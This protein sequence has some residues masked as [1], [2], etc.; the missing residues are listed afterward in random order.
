MSSADNITWTGTFTPTANTED[1]SNTL[2]LATSYTDTAG[3]AGPAATT[4]NYA[5]ET[6]AP[7]IS[8]VTAG[9]GTSLNATEDNSAGTVTVVTS[10]AENGQTVTVSLN[11]TN[12]TGTVSD[13]STSSYEYVGKLS[14]QTGVCDPGYQA[15]GEII[16]KSQAPGDCSA[17]PG[18]CIGYVQHPSASYDYAKLLSDITPGCYSMSG[19]SSWPIYLRATTTS[20]SVTVAASGLQALTDGSSYTLT[21][22]VSDAGGNAATENTGTSFTYD[23]TAPTLAET[24]LVPSLTND[25]STQ[26]TFSSSEGGTISVGGNCS[27]DNNT[28]VADNM[29][30]S[31][32][33]LADGTYSDYTITVTDSAG[34]TQT[35]SINSFT[36]DTTAPTL[37]QV[38]AVT[39]PTNDNTSSYTF[40]STEAGTIVY[41]GSCSSSTTSATSDNNSIIFNE[42]AEGPYS[43]CTVK[44]TDN[45]TNASNILPVSSFTIDIT[46]PTLAEVT[47]VTHP[48]NVTTP[49]YRFSSNEAGQITYGGSCGSS[50]TSAISGNNS[51][52]LRK[53]DGSNFSEAI[54]SNC[55]I[56]VTV[57][58][59]SI[60]GGNLKKKMKNTIGLFSLSQ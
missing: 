24:T 20:T 30:V 46:A 31:F 5:V 39:N 44:V 1:A 8:S 36:I 9:W 45:A 25:N 47:V 15:M 3:N 48:T 32:A 42:L 19:S 55:T 56:K 13:N 17:T 60:A 38:T 49:N 14:T 29:T 37:N 33:A 27:S 34:N 58:G 18:Q 59:I 50:T 10:G 12:Y 16:S 4:A 28:A 40:S 35:I 41:G 54:Y 43:N 52:N 53:S 23:I 22:N 11:G 51:V 2:S 6:L 7:T 57:I 21:T 26:Y